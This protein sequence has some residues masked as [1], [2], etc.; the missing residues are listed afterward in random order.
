ML[1]TMAMTPAL[2]L[3]GG[4]PML[5]IEAA[6]PGSAEA[7]DGA[8]YVV[9]A[10]QC[11]RALSAP[12]TARAEGV[13][14]GARRSVEVPLVRRADGTWLVKRTWPAGGSWTL[15]LS[16][17]A[18]GRAVLLARPGM[19]RIVTRLL[20]REPTREELDR[21]ARGDLTEA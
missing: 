14:D 12:V 15:V 6:A 7:R 17:E 9:H 10:T 2:A 4:P 3:A 11:G 1:M 19:E 8:A 5:T 18:H 21:A 16:V 13:V 20:H